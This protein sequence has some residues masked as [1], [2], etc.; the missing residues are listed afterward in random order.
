MCKD[1]AVI[2]VRRE[3]DKLGRICIPMEMRKLFQLEGEV[4][5]IA[6]Q[7]GV[8]IKNLEYILVKKEN[9]K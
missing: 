8:L 4:E 7:E 1:A 6:T 2:G 9:A 5:I 3:I